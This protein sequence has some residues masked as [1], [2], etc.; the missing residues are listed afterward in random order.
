VEERLTL[1]DIVA[2]GLQR[3]KANGSRGAGR[4]RYFGAGGGYVTLWARA[5]GT[6]AAHVGQER[7]ERKAGG[8]KAFACSGKRRR[9]SGGSSRKWEGAA[10]SLA[11]GGDGGGS[12]R[13]ISLGERDLAFAS[14]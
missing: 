2:A 13:R 11:G 1:A 4:R 8:G 6:E 7:K 14:I 3:R 10:R 5:T 9:Q 12:A